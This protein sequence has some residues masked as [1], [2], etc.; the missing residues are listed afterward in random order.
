MTSGSVSAVCDSLYSMRRG[1]PVPTRP[2]K[3]QKPIDAM[4]ESHDRF[5]GLIWYKSVRLIHWYEPWVRR[6][7]GREITP[8]KYLQERQHEPSETSNV[9][10][11]YFSRRRKR[12]AFL[13]V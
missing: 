1:F 6:G 5:T 10:T 8:K 3:R 9:Y 2:S 4:W 11:Q 12:A 7:L 13:P